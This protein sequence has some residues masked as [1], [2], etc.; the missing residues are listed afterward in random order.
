MYFT[1]NFFLSSLNPET[2]YHRSPQKIVDMLVDYDFLRNLGQIFF[3]IILFAGMWLI[4]LFLSSKKLISNKLWF[5]LLDD[6]FKRRF[7]FMAINDVISLFVVPIVWFAI[8]QF[9]DLKG[10]GL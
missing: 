1:P 5:N 7:K 6:T 8:W 4:L 10:T 9:K 3:F 2:T